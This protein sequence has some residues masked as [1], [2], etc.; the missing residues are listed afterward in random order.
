MQ[1]AAKLIALV[2]ELAA[3]MERRKND[4]DA[5]SLLLWV[6]VDGHAPAVIDDTQATICM[7]GNVNLTAVTGERFIDRVVDDFLSQVVWPGGVGVHTRPLP[8]RL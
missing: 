4:L 8:D 5:G 6:Q 3:G 1:S 7:E 2:R